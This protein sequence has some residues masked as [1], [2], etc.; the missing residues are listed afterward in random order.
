MLLRP[1]RD[2][3]RPEAA[4]RPPAGLVAA[5]AAAPARPRNRLGFYLESTYWRRNVH[6]HLV[7]F[8]RASG[9]FHYYDAMVR[10][11]GAEP[12]EIADCSRHLAARLDDATDGAVAASAPEAAGDEPFVA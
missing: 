7:F 9:V 10:L 4:A 1:G 6:T 11:L 5:A 2:A 3:D 8:N 12:A